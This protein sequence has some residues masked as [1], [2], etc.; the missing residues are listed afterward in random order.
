MDREPV[1]SGTLRSVGYDAA[2]QT[3]E[4]EFQDGG[5]FRY[6]AVPE[7]LY[8]GLM[9]AKSKGAFFNTRILGRYEFERVI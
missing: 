5:I 8:Q 2:T 6:A 3:L 4:A 7:F 1:A 9:L